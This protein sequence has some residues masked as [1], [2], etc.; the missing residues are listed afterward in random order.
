MGLHEDE[1]MSAEISDLFEV[2]LH[3][4]MY[5]FRVPCLSVQ[6]DLRMYGVLLRFEARRMV[7]EELNKPE[8]GDR[9]F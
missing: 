3:S 6:R 2:S 8:G 9:G 7:G 1:K 4:C 5:V